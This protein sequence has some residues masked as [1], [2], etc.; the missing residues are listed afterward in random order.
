VNYV[1]WVLMERVF[2]KALGVI[3]ALLGVA[4]ILGGLARFPPP[5]YT[6]LIDVSGGNIW[7]YGTVWLGGGLVMM[8][9]PST[10]IR[11][12]GVGLS[13]VLSNIWAALFAWAAWSYPNATF[14]ATVAYGGYGLLN[15]M[16]FV[17]MVSHNPK[18]RAW[19]RTHGR[20]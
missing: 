14:T 15:T 19:R 1:S 18:W 9:G 11:L 6:P 4:V 2:C 20:Q 3:H 10:R 12:V 16:L 17:F 5:S 8:F 13:V 7:I